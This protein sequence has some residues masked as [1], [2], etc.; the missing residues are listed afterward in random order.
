VASGL[1]IYDAL[2][3]ATT[4]LAAGEEF[5]LNTIDS[6][7]LCKLTSS[8]LVSRGYDETIAED[9]SG[10]LFRH[11]LE[12]F[13][14]SIGLALKVSSDAPRLVVEPEAD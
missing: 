14:R 5:V 11:D 2:K 4:N 3:S 13:G 7:D 6:H 9:V 1:E 8:D 10:A 12:P